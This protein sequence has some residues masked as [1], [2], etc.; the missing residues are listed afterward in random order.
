MFYKIRLFMIMKKYLLAILFGIFLISTAYALDAK[1]FYLESCPHC[2]ILAEHL[3]ELENKYPEFN[4]ERLDAAKDFPE[5][6]SLQKEY[7]IS[8]TEHGKVPKFFM[9]DF[10]CAGDTPCVDAIEAQ[11]ERQSNPDHDEN[12]P[13]NGNNNPNNSTEEINLFTLLWLAF[14]DSINPCEMAILIILMTSIL[15]K[16][17]QD[18]NKAALIGLVFTSAIFLMYFIFG[19]ILILGFKSTVDFMAFD[20]T[21][22]Y[23]ILGAIAI[24]LGVMNLKDGIWYGGGGFIIEVPQSWRPK[25]K[26]IITGTT[27]LIGAFIAGLIVSFFLTPCTAGPYVVAAGLLSHMPLTAAIPIL[28]M[29]LFVFILPM[30][31][32]IGV[33]YFGIATVEKLSGWRE[34]NL[35]LLH[36]VAGAM[37][38]LLGIAMIFGLL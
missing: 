37:L 19:M 7:G 25:M 32:I 4:V 13:V 8:V 17:P 6:V 24:L 3:N 1:F 36:L 11:I 34:K 18:K 10:W 30:L 20:K 9:G 29:Y 38:V 31:I 28:L 5:Y 2:H 15:T 16:F 22:F 35:K 33:V 14:L 26:Q 12:S 21:W 27:T 23:S